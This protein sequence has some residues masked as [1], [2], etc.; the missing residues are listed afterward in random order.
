MQ[1]VE[2][3][4]AHRA[5]RIGVLDLDV[6]VLGQQR[7]QVGRHHLPPVDLAGIERGGSRGRIRDVDP[8]DAVDLHDLAARRPGRRLLARHVVGVLRRTR[9][10]CPAPTPLSRILKGPEPIASV[11]FVNASVLA[12]RSGMMNGTFEEGFAS[13]SSVSGNGFF[14]FSVKVLSSTA[15][16][17]SVNSASFWPSASRLAQRSIEAMQSADSDRLAV[18]ELEAVAQREGVG[19]LVVA[20]GPLARPSAAGPRTSRSPRTACRRPCSRSCA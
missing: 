1:L 6:L 19:E 10:C 8:L 14:S 9:P 7:D 16:Q 11:I 3:D 2:A 13:A 18:V 12:T 5:Q 17:E 20:Q 15:V 4:H